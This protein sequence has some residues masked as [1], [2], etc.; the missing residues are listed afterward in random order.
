MNGSIEHL[1]QKAAKT[2]T[3]NIVFRCSFFAIL[4][5]CRNYTVAMN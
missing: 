4:R 1:K 2:Q 3:L 5:L